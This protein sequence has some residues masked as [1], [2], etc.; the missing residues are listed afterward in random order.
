MRLFTKHFIS[1]NNWSQ[2][3]SSTVII[4]LLQQVKL[5]SSFTGKLDD[6]VSGRNSSDSSLC[7][8]AGRYGLRISSDSSF[9]SAMT[10]DSDH[11]SVFGDTS[12]PGPFSA[13]STTDNDSCFFSKDFSSQESNRRFSSSGSPIQQRH[14]QPLGRTSSSGLAGRGGGSSSSCSSMSPS[15]EETR[16]STLFGTLPRKSRKASVRK[17]IFKLIP[18]LQRSVEEEEV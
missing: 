14:H 13:A 16:I 10:D 18:G 6:D 15:W 17:Q 7:S 8:P 12:S 9:R 2:N 1:T 3:L 11:T 5:L 4:F